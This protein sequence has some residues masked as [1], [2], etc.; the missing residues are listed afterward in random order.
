MMG[1][2]TGWICTGAPRTFIQYSHLRMILIRGI[3]AA[4]IGFK[5]EA[6]N[7]KKRLL[8]LIPG[9]LPSSP[10]LGGCGMDQMIITLYKDSHLGEEGQEGVQSGDYWVIMGFK[11][12]LKAFRRSEFGEDNIESSLLSFSTAITLRS[13]DTP[14]LQC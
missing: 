12:K 13:A 9:L 5:L 3:H 8:E 1:G 10:E 6:L 7:R 11:N 14:F 4:K 2:R